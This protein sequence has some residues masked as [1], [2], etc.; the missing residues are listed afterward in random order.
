[1]RNLQLLTLLPNPRQRVGSRRQ[2]WQE[3]QL[4][5]RCKHRR[6]HEGRRRDGR[7]GRLLSSGEAA[8]EGSSSRALGEYA[9][10]AR[11]DIRSTASLPRGL[12]HR[13]F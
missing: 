10:S 9:V 8:A 5:G 11:P 13:K 12:F 1:M 7:A 4:R 3:R 6:L 2:V